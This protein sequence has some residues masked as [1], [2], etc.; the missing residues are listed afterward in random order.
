MD[1]VNGIVVFGFIQIL[2]FRNN[3]CVIRAGD[4]GKTTAKFVGIELA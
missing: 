1:A 3:E 2:S 4:G